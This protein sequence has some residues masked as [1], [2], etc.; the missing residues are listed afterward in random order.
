MRSKITLWALL[1]II[2]T[3]A[4]AD[5]LRLRNGTTVEGKFV[6]GNEKGIWF[7]HA[8]QGSTLYPLSFIE[9]VTFGVYTPYSSILKQ[10]KGQSAKAMR[11][12]ESQQED[13]S[14]IHLPVNSFR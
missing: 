2:C 14:A 5:V 6:S 12:R 4:Q 13:R 3:A 1:L 7:E 8:P 10:P 11:I 9:G